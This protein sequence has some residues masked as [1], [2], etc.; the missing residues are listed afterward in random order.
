MSGMARR[1]ME[2]AAGVLA[3]GLGL[4][5]AWMDSRPHW[6]D[7][8]ITAGALLLSAGAI[9]L[10]SGR[11]PWL[12]GLLVGLGVFVELARPALAAHRFSISMATLGPFVVLAIPMAGAYGAFFM[13]RA[14]TR[15]HPA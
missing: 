15:R 9:A 2:A 11:R 7:S 14:I 6:D 10:I 5:I 8:G 3:L 12:V 4:A 1:G 13:R